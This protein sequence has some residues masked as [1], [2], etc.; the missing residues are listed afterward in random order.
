LKISIVGGGGRVG[1]PL[2]IVLAGAGHSV[3]IIDLDKN[4][5]NSINSRTMPFF[6]SG[7]AEL[8]N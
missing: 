2:G 6:E 7:A 8:L 5:V 3:S 4:R 1:L